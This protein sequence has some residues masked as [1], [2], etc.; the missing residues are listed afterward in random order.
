M[1]WFEFASADIEMR[2]MITSM[3][4]IDLGLVPPSQYPHSEIGSLQACLSSL[5]PES[6]RK[7]CRKFR[8][9]VR[10]VRDKKCRTS[11]FYRK[12]RTVRYRIEQSVFI[13]PEDNDE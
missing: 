3:A 5:D 4:Y 10:N 13:D 2:K 12:Q 8:K 6:R 11:S 1:S 9:L 7:A